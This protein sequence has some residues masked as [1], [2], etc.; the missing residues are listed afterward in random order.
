MC[1]C[2]LHFTKVLWS[3]S[4]RSSHTFDAASTSSQQSRV[5]NLPL[6]VH[7]R[8]STTPS[9]PQLPCYSCG[10]WHNTGCSHS[11]SC[12]HPGITISLH[13]HVAAAHI[14]DSS[15]QGEHPMLSCHVL[16]HLP[17]TSISKFGAIHLTCENPGNRQNLKRVSHT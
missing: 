13:V 2:K 7:A 6:L 16:S 8:L 5:T 17:L 1:P 9:L 11:S 10:H 15:C 3:P 12:L 14:L 4:T